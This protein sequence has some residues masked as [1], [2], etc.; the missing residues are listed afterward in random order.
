MSKSVRK[1]FPKYSV[2]MAVYKNDDVEWFKQAVDSILNQTSK[3][4]DIIIVRDGKVP[5]N[6]ENELVAYENLRN[7][8]K[9]VRLEENVGAGQARNEG[10]LRAANGYVAVMDAD[11]ISHP[12]RFKLQLAEFD[13][14]PELAL[15]GGQISEFED[16]Q[17]NIVSYRKVPTGYADIMK[18][19]RYRSPINHVT[20]M[21][22]KSIFLKVGGYP[23]MNRAE[24]YYMVSSLLA[25]GYL[26][27]NLKEIIVNCRVSSENIRRRKTWNN[28]RE[29]IISRW[30]IYQLGTTSFI[31]FIVSSIAQIMLFIIP[32][33]LLRTLFNV[34]LRSKNG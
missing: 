4:N 21:F 33:P 15:V 11:D 18:F 9:I 10:V 17:D 23:R 20:I 16:S 24:D 30:K 27:G 32:V 12:N 7:E 13:R 1:T 19:A 2:V 22:N 31:N 6:L 5:E 34:A 8:V 28:V 3:S 14:N 29:N 25:G 26:V